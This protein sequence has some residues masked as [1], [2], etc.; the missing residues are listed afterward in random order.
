MK[1]GGFSDQSGTKALGADLHS[2]RSSLFD[3]L[4][5]MK[6]G[7]PDLSGFVISMTDIVAKDRPFPANLTYFCHR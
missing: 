1:L 2:N 7:I 3:R 6:V 5:F 4:H